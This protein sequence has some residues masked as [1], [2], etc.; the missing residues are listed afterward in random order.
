M[1]NLN[2]YK[3][4][5]LG[6]INPGLAAELYRIDGYDLAPEE[7]IAAF[8]LDDTLIEGDIGEAVFCYI[9][10]AGNDIPL[11]WK[12]YLEMIEA[13]EYERGYCDIITS[14]EGMNIKTI[15]NSAKNLISSNSEIIIFTED[16]IE[17]N[18]PIPKPII[19][20]QNLIVYLK[21]SGWKISVISSSSQIAVRSVTDYLFKLYPEYV[22]GIK[23]E[24]YVTDNY[25]DLFTTKIQG[26]V[27]FREGKAEVFR[28]M[29]GDL[30]PLITAGD[31]RGDIELLNLTSDKGFAILC[32]KNLS[33]LEFLKN[34][35][36]KNIKIIE[37][38]E[39]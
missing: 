3:A 7:K 18:Y 17:Y 38:K 15:A 37:F 32:G 33:N 22:R 1:H 13:K 9:K 34:S 21:I 30:Q 19:E 29:F 31:S 10:A 25:D 4:K 14:M 39:Q 36:S 20:M 28:D 2:Q 23:T 16:G 8:D 35:I 24:I 5:I 27:P 11:K 26:T 6:R 12:D